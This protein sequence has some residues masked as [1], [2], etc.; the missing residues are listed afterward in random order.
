MTATPVLYMP[1]KPRRYYV[2]KRV[3]FV[4]L[5]FFGMFNVHALRVN[6]SVAI[7]AMVNNTGTESGNAS[8]VEDSCPDLRNAD[9]GVTIARQTK[10][11]QFNWDAQTKGMVISSF[12]YAYF[13]T[14]L[15]GG[16]LAKKF[17]AK[18]VYGGGIIL[19]SVLTLLTPVAVRWGIVPFLV[20]RALEG[21]GEGLSYPAMNTMISRWAPQMERSRISAAVY[22]GSAIGTVVSLTVSGWLCETDFLGGWPAVFYVFGKIFTAWLDGI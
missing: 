22:S 16:Y 4:I 14:V 15:T 18:R 3:I 9:N 5:G 11:E 1:E 7:V 17:G 12:F 21:I 8:Y 6:L 13:I 10:G 2:P 20:V 19:T